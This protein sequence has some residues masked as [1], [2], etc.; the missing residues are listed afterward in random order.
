MRVHCPDEIM[1]VISDQA[2]Q[3]YPKEACGLLIGIK[4]DTGWRVDQAI[5]SPNRSDDPIH[6]FR[7]DAALQ[8]Q[9]QRTARTNHQQI[10]GCY[11][12]HPNGSIEPSP[13][14]CAQ[15]LDAH[16]PDLWLIIAGRPVTTQWYLW[17]D[18]GF[19]HLMNR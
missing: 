7:I 8:C 18:K 15:A 2:V 16:G 14:D 13:E 3:E 4:T 1:R 17:H 6:F 19:T 12:S 11:H 5:P 10:I 9:I